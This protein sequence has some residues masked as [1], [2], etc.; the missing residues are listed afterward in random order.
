MFVRL[1]LVANLMYF[2]YVNNTLTLALAVH[3][4]TRH[5]WAA[6]G[7]SRFLVEIDILEFLRP[8]HHSGKAFRCSLDELLSSELEKLSKLIAEK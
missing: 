8:I 5:F 2:I 1:N 3:E 4:I 6:Y 7:R